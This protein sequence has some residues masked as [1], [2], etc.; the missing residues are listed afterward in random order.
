MKF[1]TIGELRDR[2]TFQ[3]ER[4][5][6]DGYGGRHVVWEDC[7]SVWAKVEPLR[8][9]EYF[10][11]HQIKSE[12]THRVLIRFRADVMTD[13]RIIYQGRVFSIDSVIDVNGAGRYLEILCYEDKS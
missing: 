7:G 13:M 6:D 3:K 5:R 11:A 10:Y 4:S 1:P 8:G 12:I 9:R 2:I